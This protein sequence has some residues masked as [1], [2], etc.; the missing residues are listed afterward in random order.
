MVATSAPGWLLCCIS[1]E[2]VCSCFLPAVPIFRLPDNRLFKS[3]TTTNT[4]TAY[5]LPCQWE[6]YTGSQGV[7]P[8]R[9]TC[10]KNKNGPQ[11]NWCANGTY[12]AFSLLL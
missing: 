10:L 11:S 5:S 2:A 12:S 6:L 8:F 3:K 4:V 7:W 1:E 9:P